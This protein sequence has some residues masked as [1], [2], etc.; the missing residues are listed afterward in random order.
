MR[1]AAVVVLILA[2][3]HAAQAQPMPVPADQATQGSTA[4]AP[5]VA[6]AGRSYR[7]LFGAGSGARP[8]GHLLDLT[9]SVYQEY[10]TLSRSEFSFDPEVQGIGW[11]LGVRSRLA[12][13]RAWQNTRFGLRGES[14]FRYF[15]DARE[16]TTPR[17]RL[18]VAL[19][20]NARQYRL[21]SVRLSGSGDYEPYYT[22]SIFPT[23]V[24]ETGGT[25]IVPTSRD[26]LL[27]R[28]AR[29]VYAQSFEAERQVAP[30][31]Y[32]TVFESWRYTSASAAGFDVD[33]VRVGARYGYRLSRY[34]SLRVGYA[35]Q[36]G[37]YGLEAARR[38]EAHDIDLSYDYRKPLSR[39]RRTTVGFG[40]GSSRVTTGAGPEWMIVGTANLR[41]ELGAGSFLQGD[42]L[43]N[44]QL[45]EGF[46]EP[47]FVNTGSA[48]L[49]GFFGRRVEFLASSGYSMGTIGTGSDTYES[50]QGSARL[51]L[52]MASFLAVDVEGLVNRNIFDGRTTLPGV[53]PATTG[54]ASRWAVRCN[55]AMWL[56]L[57]R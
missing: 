30:R 57:S 4:A 5:P 15:R 14:S 2:A 21:N 10:G 49:G 12:L 34:A 50:L 51:R 27:F 35:Y 36:T 44:V 32:V 26:D 13:E 19:D 28:G 18:E 56:P 33:S 9:A 54:D 38:L 8:G 45:V 6:Q 53:I 3:G 37:H 42:Y 39:S 46:A 40:V 23:P 20:H 25:A 52:A 48:S 16:T 17:V 43:R 31:A 47:F 41:H 7:G 29:Y 11:F 55:V 24:A 1:K 22:L